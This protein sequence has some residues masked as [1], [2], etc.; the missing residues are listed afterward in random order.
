MFEMV[1]VYI[2]R[3]TMHYDICTP[4]IESTLNKKKMK[5]EQHYAG[6]DSD[7][8]S[9]PDAD[10][11]WWRSCATSEEMSALKINSVSEMADWTP[12]LKVMRE[13]ERLAIVA[14][15]GLD[16]IR[17]RLVAY[18]A[19]DLWVPVGGVQREG[20]NIPP[21][22]TILLV[23]FSGGGKSSL[24]NLMYS[25][26]GRAGIIPFAQTS[27]SSLTCGSTTMMLEEHNVTR[28]MRAGF[29]IY[30]SR[31]F[32]YN[33][34]QGESLAELSEWTVQGV[35]HNQLCPRLRDPIDHLSVGSSSKF[36]KRRVNCAMVVANMA[37]L[38]EELIKT[39]GSSKHLDSTKQVFSYSALK[40]GNQNPI[41]ILTHGDTLAATD[42]INARLKICEYM[43]I[44]E[45]SGVYDIVCMTEYGVAPE[46]CDPVT[47]YSLT[48]AVYRAL[49]ISDMSHTPKLNYID[50]AIFYLTCLLQFIGVFFALLARIFSGPSRRYNKMI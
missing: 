8:S 11:H 50:K 46:E 31:G 3:H 47:A 36:A 4:L 30:D 14:P 6:G 1:G 7:D 16:D 18:R 34:R 38:Y 49:L 5:E 21:Q 41:L 45:T 37:E 23:G 19:G 32:D 20:M 13:L 9:Q 33:D 28:S 26:L 29:C 2:Y 17:H 24:V 25:V 43:G 35:R 15:D 22:V 42:R 48:E 39:G 27:G 40:R 44:S 10:F 12:R